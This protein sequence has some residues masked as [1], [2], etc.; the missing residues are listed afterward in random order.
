MRR[1]DTWQTIALVSGE[2]P[3]TGFTTDGGTRARVLSLWGSPF[4][5][6]DPETGRVVRDLDRGVREHYGHAGPQFVRELMCKRDRWPAFRTRY[7]ARQD[8]YVAR[9]G[10]NPVAARAAAYCAALALCAELAHSTLQLPWEFVNPVDAVWQEMTAEAEQADQAGEGAA[11]RGQLGGPEPGLFLRGQR[12]ACS[13][14]VRRMAGRWDLGGPE[15]EG[16]WAPLGFLPPRLQQILKTG[17]YDFNA[18]VRTWKDRNWLQVNDARKAR[19]RVRIKEA[20][21]WVVMIRGEVVQDVLENG[22]VPGGRQPG[23]RLTVL[24][25]T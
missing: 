21:A 4:G 15:A 18:V 5:R 24:W 12:P 10:A 16:G 13:P 25:L 6:T 8:E 22:K 20:T 2:A 3:A 14:S 7:R 1:A 9:A 19:Y 17:G 11:L 23:V